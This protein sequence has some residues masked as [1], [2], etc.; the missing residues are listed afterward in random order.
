MVAIENLIVNIVQSLLTGL[1]QGG[2]YALISIGLTLIFGVMGIINFAQ[3]DFMMLGMYGSLVIVGALT[4]NPLIVFFLLIPVFLLLGGAV[5]KTLIN[6][7]ID[8]QED[9]QLILTFGIL[10]ILENGALAVFGPS[11]ESLTV[12]YSVTAIPIGPF[13]INQAKAI[14]FIFA[15]GLAG[16]M[17]LFLRYTEFG[18]AMRATANNHDVA[19]YSGINVGNM[20]TAA[21]ALGIM[22]TACAGSLLIMY[23]PASPTVGFDFILLMFVVVV[24]GGLGSIKGALVA[25]LLIG[26]I[27]QVS[28]IW[29]PLE[30]QPG[31]VFVLFLIVLLVKPEGL[32]G[33]ATREV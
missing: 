8:E 13:T 18:R 3:A 4:I 31:V 24:L 2:V 10:L 16:T 11:P 33:E 7:I 30:I 9:A 19:S 20:Y 26:V 14:A 12:S 6:H 17:F 28:V 29:L 21:F 32:Y 27:E 23:Y 15:L 25:G 1:M 22:L 5:Q